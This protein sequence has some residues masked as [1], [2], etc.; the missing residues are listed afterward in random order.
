MRPVVVTSVPDDPYA[1]H[2]SVGAHEFF[3][4]EAAGGDRAPDPYEYLVAALGACTAMTLRMYAKQKNIALDDV[5]VELTYGRDHVKDCEDCRTRRV[6]R[7]ERKVTLTGDLTDAERAQLL[8]IA[9]RCPVHRTLV[10]ASEI[11]TTLVD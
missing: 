6:H 9:E 5:S 1:Q 3:I 8:D 11:S 4:D 2:V 10:E 7:I